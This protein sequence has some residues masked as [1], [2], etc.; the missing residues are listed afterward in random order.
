MTMPAV[1]Q[2]SP[3][4]PGQL[5]P[6]FT[7][8]AVEREGTVSLA[9]YRG[10]SAVLLTINR[11]LWCSFCR[12]HIAQLSRVRDRLQRLKVETLA[13]VASDLA[14]TRL[15]VRHRPLNVPL[16]ADPAQLTHRAY[17]V[18]RPV[19]TSEF[20]Q[21][22]EKMATMPLDL[23]DVAVNPTDLAELQ[24]AVRTTQVDPA[25]GR[26]STI[27][28]WDFILLQRKLYPYAMT[29][30]DQQEWERNRTLGTGQ[31]LVDRDGVIRSSVV[32]QVTDHPAGIGNYPDETEL[33]AAAQAL[34][35]LR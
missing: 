16:A 18:P 31:F 28:I 2:G 15:Y 34:R 35:E 20:E 12:R 33:L 6:D 7:L 13:I 9:D 4:Q 14:P 5:A 22:I 19:R 1:A 29:E 30:R 10:R 21:A 24:A 8:A 27:A 3:L 11:G 32:Q 23:Q 25:S 26:P 17:G